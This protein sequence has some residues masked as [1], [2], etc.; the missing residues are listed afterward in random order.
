[1]VVN[2]LAEKRVH[3]PDDKQQN[4]PKTTETNI[5]F[6]SVVKFSNRN[7]PPCGITY[8][9]HENLVVRD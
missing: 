2:D 8:I 5:Q 9:R 4:S 1:M 6:P 3:Q 7:L